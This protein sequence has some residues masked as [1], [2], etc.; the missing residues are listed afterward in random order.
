MFNK[1]GLQFVTADW[2]FPEEPKLD[3]DQTIVELEKVAL[4]AL[5]QLAKAERR[6]EE[7]ERELSYYKG[8]L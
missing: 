2:N 7:L 4:Q 6:I 8:S 1:Y 5:E 3:K